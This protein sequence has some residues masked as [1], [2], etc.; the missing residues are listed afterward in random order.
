MMPG[1]ERE[2]E[3]LEALTPCGGTSEEVGKYYDGL[4]EI[5][6]GQ[7]TRD[8][9]H[10][11]WI[12]GDETRTEAKQNVAL[13]VGDRLGL[14]PGERCVDIGCGYGDMARHLSKAKRVSVTA[15]TNSAR[16]HALAVQEKRSEGVEYHLADWCTN[17][18]PDAA[19]DAAWAVESLE[20][21]LDLDAA[22]GQC[23][24]VLRSGGRLLV[25]SW[26]ARARV[27]SW[28]RIVFL[29]PTARQF[30]LSPLRTE[31]RMMQA[32]STAGF[33]Y[34]RVSDLTRNV[35]RT[36]YPTASGILQRLRLKAGAALEPGISWT[37]LRT[38]GAYAVGA[39]RYAAF[40]A[41]AN[42]AADP[43]SRAA[44]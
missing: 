32:L 4:D 23:R 12:R 27:P 37:I 18:L 34:I 17:D 1:T 41:V 5:Y 38:A 10:G 26:L 7:V 19:Y 11:L 40:S 42:G 25:L 14:K 28:E 16:Q 6:R 9:H 33:G 44:G 30:R 24:R 43:G 20:H 21:V 35:R 2:L 31:E 39:L 15:V 13:W 29:A 3:R 8:V 22:F 36:W